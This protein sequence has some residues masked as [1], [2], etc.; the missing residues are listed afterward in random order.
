MSNSFITHTVESRRLDAD[1]WLVVVQTG[2]NPDSATAEVY[3]LQ[4]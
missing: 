3:C 1:S 4:A 2:A